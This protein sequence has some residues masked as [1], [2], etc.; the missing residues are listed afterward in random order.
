MGFVGN[1]TRI[2]L[3]V[4]QC[5]QFSSEMFSIAGASFIEKHSL[6]ITWDQKLKQV[7]SWLKLIRG[8]LAG[9][10]GQLLSASGMHL[11]IFVSK[12]IKMWQIDVQDYPEMIYDL[13]WPLCQ[14]GLITGNCNY[15]QKGTQSTSSGFTVNQSAKSNKMYQVV[16][17]LVHLFE[18]KKQEKKLDRLSSVKFDEYCYW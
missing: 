6:Y 11:E 17:W 9:S 18:A 7:S 16:L 13:H 2:E 1:I 12:S 15:H 10:W 3:E 8:M 5:Y 4:K 14:Q